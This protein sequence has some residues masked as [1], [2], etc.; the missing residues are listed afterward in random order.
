MSPTALQR[1]PTESPPWVERL[2]EE[3]GSWDNY[4]P[5]NN[6]N[7]DRLVKQV[8]ASMEAVAAGVLGL[9]FDDAKW[10]PLVMFDG[11]PKPN[12]IWWLR[13]TFELTAEQAAKAFTLSL[14][15]PS[16][17]YIIY[18]NQRK[19]AEE[20][21]QA[22]KLELPPG[23]FK[24]GT[25]LLVMRLGNYWGYPQFVGDPEDVYLRAHDGG[26]DV[27]MKTGWKYSGELEPP[28][29]KWLPLASI[30]SSLY[31]G[32]ISPLLQSPIK[33]VIWY[34]GEQN[35]GKPETYAALFQAMISD[36]RIQFNEGC[37]PFYYV[38][39]ANFGAPS[40]LPANDGWALVREAQAR[41]LVVPN[42]GMATA[43]DVGEA[44][45]VHPKNKQA[46]G[47]RL[48]LQ[49]LAQ[50]YGQKIECNGPV[51]RSFEA[52]DHCLVIHFDHAQGLKTR[53]GKA[54]E[55]FAVAGDDRVFV[56]ANAS[57]KGD[58][59][60]VYSEKIALP[61]AVRYNFCASPIGN[62]YN[63]ADL[64]MYPFRTDDWKEINQGK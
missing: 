15:R 64:P 32:M 27:P 12:Q 13:K 40:A 23:T 6:D 52:K 36:W 38:Q 42:T 43:C 5:T 29:A 59:V 51:Y 46:V 54:P 14:A 28:L 2:N 22:C 55:G 4:V 30:P 37:F 49:A 25:N 47:H 33:G 48:A 61:K 11:L 41:T 62:V 63:A 56:V 39:L 16:E 57:I 10:Q 34:Q 18:V 26:L 53:N 24:A 3:Y 60:E 8:D 58:H 21:S 1:F 50:T 7:I 45:D 17:N 44:L 31:N 20:R 9:G 35:T 19:V